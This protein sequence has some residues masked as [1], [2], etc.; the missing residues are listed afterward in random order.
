MRITSSPG[1]VSPSD[2]ELTRDGSVS[3]SNLI[4]IFITSKVFFFFLKNRDRNKCFV[5]VQK[6][7]VMSCNKKKSSNL[8]YY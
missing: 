5:L 3:N 7:D 8:L 6:V 2:A 4:A 1:H